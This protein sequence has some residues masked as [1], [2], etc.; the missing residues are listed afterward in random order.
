[1]I[2]GLLSGR[3]SSIGTVLNCLIAAYLRFS[4]TG[5]RPATPDALVF[6][7]KN[8]YTLSVVRMSVVISVLT[9]D[10]CIRM[11]P[12]SWISRVLLECL[13]PH[14]FLPLLSPF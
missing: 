8:Q 4:I 6:G 12:F 3:T 2:I 5:S 1:V 10:S 9:K 14:F 13:R 7:A 11:W